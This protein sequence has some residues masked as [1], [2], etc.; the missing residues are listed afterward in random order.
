MKYITSKYHQYKSTPVTF[1][2]GI[3]LVLVL[4]VSC[5]NSNKEDSLIKSNKSITID[6]STMIKDSIWFKAYRYFNNEVLRPEI[7]SIMQKVSDDEGIEISSLGLFNMLIQNYDCN[8]LKASDFQTKYPFSKT[9][10]VKGNFNHLVS[11]GLFERKDSIYKLTKK[12]KK[13]LSV[14]KN[15]YQK[16]DDTEIE[17]FDLS[18][19]KKVSKLA[20]S[21]QFNGINKS[22]K[23][24]QQA[25]LRFDD[26]K[27]KFLQLFTAMNDLVAL[28][29]DQSHYRYSFFKHKPFEFNEELNHPMI[30][31]LAGISSN[32]NFHTNSFK[33]R[34]TWGYTAFETKE[35]LDFLIEKELVIQED[36][37]Y[38]L[39]NK[40]IEIEQRA[41][42]KC[43]EHFYQPWPFM[44]NEEY[45]KFKTLLK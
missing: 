40:A 25:S 17:T 41:S 44:T 10:F 28:R 31:L 37:T 24:C 3:L 26:S 18:L 42:A 8:T 29:N 38:K 14:L 1:L 30:E 9:E 15:N 2:F 5:K 39:T 23:N 43:E 13:L 16:I 22:L 4:G 33:S 20:L 7:V 36:S 11:K 19:L 21:N 32:S 6:K 12:G 27:N 45:Q 35:Y 34:A